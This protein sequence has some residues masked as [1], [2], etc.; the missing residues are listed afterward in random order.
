MLFYVHF[1]F[2][3]G[4]PHVHSKWACGIE[5]EHKRDSVKVRQTWREPDRQLWSE[6]TARRGWRKHRRK[7]TPRGPARLSKGLDDIFPQAPLSVWVR[8]SDFEESRLW[9]FSQGVAY[10]EYGIYVH[11]VYSQYL[12]GWWRCVGAVWVKHAG[13]RGNLLSCM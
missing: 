13:A 6:H 3:W 10:L 5:G 8:P 11:I 9:K 7:F 4:H 2:F 12:G 1:C